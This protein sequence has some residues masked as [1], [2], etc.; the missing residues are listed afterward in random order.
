[1]ARRSK[2]KRNRQVAAPPGTLHY[3]GVFTQEPTTITLLRY[4][5]DGFERRNI[6]V[7]QIK[8]A[9]EEPGIKWFNYYGFNEPEKLKKVAEAL[10][11]HPLIMES[12]LD[13]ESVPRVEEFQDFIFFQLKMLVEVRQEH[14]GPEHISFILGK[15][16]LFCFQEKLRD[17]FDPIRKRMEDPNS[18]VRQTG[19][20][21]LL[22]R[23][24]DTLIDH[25]FISVN[26]IEIEL[27][28][29]EEQIL[30]HPDRQS[31]LQILELKKRLSELR[32][33]IFPLMESIRKLTVGEHLYLEEKNRFYFVQLQENLRFLVS[34][35]DE[36][37]D[38]L[39]SYVDL[40]LST[41]SFKQNE[42]ISTLTIVGSIFIPLSFISS[43]Y[44]MNF[45]NMPELQTKNGYF[46]ALGVML[47][48]GVGMWVYMKR[49]DW[50]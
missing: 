8:S 23:L 30:N 40:Y 31:I 2:K 11:I 16:F 18:R 24:I 27:E 20:D 15:D 13:V 19:P 41:L 12:V 4:D 3:T 46:I 5:V 29:L 9:L 32:R 48:L 42:V 26:S 33:A 37:M 28:Q 1:M 44:G 17:V 10:K 36:K 21:Y 39:T 50:F 38:M 47:V 43:I 45:V 22:N 25:Y 7:N 14:E 49:K 35:V 6:D 34:T